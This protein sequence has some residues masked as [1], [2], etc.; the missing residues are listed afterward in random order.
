MPSGFGDDDDSE[1]A[2]SS[3][4]KQ[5]EPLLT[6][7]QMLMRYT[8]QIMEK[9]M[10]CVAKCQNMNMIKSQTLTKNKEKDKTL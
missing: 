1:D 4:D 6:W 5:S 7:T 2:T 10:M 8:D 9:M 3:R